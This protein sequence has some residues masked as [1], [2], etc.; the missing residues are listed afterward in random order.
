MKQIL[1]TNIPLIKNLN[2]QNSFG[3]GCFSP[4]CQRTQEE[5]LNA[6]F[7]SILPT[8]KIAWVYPEQ[9]ISPLM[10]IRIADMIQQWAE[11]NPEREIAITTT[12]T[13]WLS[14]IQFDKRVEDRDGIHHDIPN[15]YGHLLSDLFC[16]MK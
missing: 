7:N 2:Q 4:M 13:I 16:Y 11:D 5:V 8:K 15:T 10:Q 1:L 14:R 3:L 12:S 6:V 9:L